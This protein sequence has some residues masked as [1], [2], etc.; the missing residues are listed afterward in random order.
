ME[1]NL[2]HDPDST[3]TPGASSRCSFLNTLPLPRQGPS[4]AST[5]PPSRSPPAARRRRLHFSLRIRRAAG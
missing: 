3:P 1:S 4:I 2:P 5:R